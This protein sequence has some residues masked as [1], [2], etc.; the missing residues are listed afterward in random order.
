LRKNRNIR[1]RKEKR[2]KA[3]KLDAREKGEESEKKAVMYFATEPLH[4]TEKK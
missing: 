4:L 2:M 1:T 3:Q